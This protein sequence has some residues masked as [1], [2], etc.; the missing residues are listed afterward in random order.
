MLVD[1]DDYDQFQPLLH[2]EASSSCAPRTSP[3]CIG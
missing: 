1:R 2:Q 3:G